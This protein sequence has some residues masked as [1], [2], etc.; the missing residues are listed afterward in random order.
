MGRS[1]DSNIYGADETS[2]ATAAS[3]KAL[4]VSGTGVGSVNLSDY[5]G[6]TKD[7]SMKSK[8]NLEARAMG[9][10]KI[11]RKMVGGGGDKES[12][13]ASTKGGQRHRPGPT[14]S[15]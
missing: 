3:S 9:P 14:T 6:D 2:Q 10:V 11:L 15:K 7:D 8:G 5:W 4:D 12:L 13:D 1:L